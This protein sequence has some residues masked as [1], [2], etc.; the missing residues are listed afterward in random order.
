MD[1]LLNRKVLCEGCKE[2]KMEIL[3]NRCG[4]EEMARLLYEP[5]FNS[6][7][8]GY[9]RWYP[10]NEFGNIEHLARGGFGEVSKAKWFGSYYKHDYDSKY[11]DYKEEDVVLKRLY[12][13]ND[14]I[15]DILKEVNKKKV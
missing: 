4:N 3:I 13:S 14:N 15:L 7:R 1:D 6:T 10:F 9:V 8:I 12:D 2:K 5:K 11:N